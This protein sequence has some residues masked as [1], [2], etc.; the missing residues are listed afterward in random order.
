M[1]L[2][3]LAALAFPTKPS[4]STSRKYN[5]CKTLAKNIK[6]IAQNKYKHDIMKIIQLS[7]GDE[8]V[9]RISILIGMMPER[10]KI[11]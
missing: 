6:T 3:V 11:I 2:A 4:L 1:L 5:L 7:G 8:V 9:H 10:E